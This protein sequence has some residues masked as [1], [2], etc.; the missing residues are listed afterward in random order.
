MHK[1]RAVEAAR[2]LHEVS[3][4][5]GSIFAMPLVLLDI[6]RALTALQEGDLATLSRALE[7]SE[8]RCREF[9]I[10]LLWHIERFRALMRINVGHGAEGRA[11]L[12][13]L[14]QRAEN[15][16]PVGAT[17]LCAYDQC[18]VLAASD[19]RGDSWQHALAQDADD[20]PNIW[21][22]K[23]RALAT[24]GWHDEARSALAAVPAEAL[25]RLPCDR[26]YLG[27]LGALARAALILQAPDYAHAVYAPLAPYPEYFA[28][29]LAFLCEGSVPQL[30]GMLARSR[31]DRA[32]ARQHLTSAIAASEQAGLSACASEARHEY[33]LC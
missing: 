5:Q 8:A 17:V 4:K 15:A 31:G 7:R 26:E 19:R 14:H 23:V 30:L 10:E 9:D 32:T 18:V 24:A 6:H 21:A 11:A 1:P 27:T 22:L 33:S 13:A 16:G 12:L 28:A 29:N 20:P 2:W 3:T 25:A